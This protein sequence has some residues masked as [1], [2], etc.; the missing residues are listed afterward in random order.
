MRLFLLVSMLSG[1][2]NGT[3]AS[4]PT[5]SPS[6]NTVRLSTT[7]GSRLSKTSLKMRPLSACPVTPGT[8]MPPGRRVGDDPGR[9]GIGD[10]DDAWVLP[11]VGEVLE[12]DRLED[13]V[14]VGP[15]L[16][17]RLVESLEGST[18]LDPFTVVGFDGELGAVDRDDSRDAPG[19]GLHQ[20][21]VDL[22]PHGSCDLGLPAGD[23]DVE[24]LWNPE[25][26]QEDVR[27]QLLLDL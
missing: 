9:A 16:E 21:G 12:P 18:R 25:L 10:V 20:V 15:V 7:V 3:K 26:P 1:A 6:A 17:R 27:A 11:V 8:V 19:E 14:V 13:V 24:V 5:A 22:R 23:G 2:R 4:V